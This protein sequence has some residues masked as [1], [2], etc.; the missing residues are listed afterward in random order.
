MG[1]KEQEA[2]AVAVRVHGKGN[3]G[4]RPR[5]QVVSQLLEQIALRSAD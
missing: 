2:K 4:V 5:E 1:A 3:Q